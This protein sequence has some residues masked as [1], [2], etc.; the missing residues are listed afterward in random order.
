MEHLVEARAFNYREGEVVC[1]DHLCKEPNDSLLFI[2]L[3]TYAF[4]ATV[5]YLQG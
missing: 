5:R 4:F 3:G 2:D 1:E